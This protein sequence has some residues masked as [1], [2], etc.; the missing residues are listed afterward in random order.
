MS[1]EGGR[2]SKKQKKC[3]HSLWTSSSEKITFFHKSKK[4]KKKKIYLSSQASNG[5]LF[6]LLHG[7]CFLVEKPEI[8]KMETVLLPKIFFSSFLFFSLCLF[9]KDKRVFP[10]DKEKENQLLC[11]LSHWCQLQNF[12]KFP[13]N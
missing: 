12:S 9:T 4:K 1:T 13:I 10:L 7:G 6:L 5:F 8:E 2:W 3:Q 11:R